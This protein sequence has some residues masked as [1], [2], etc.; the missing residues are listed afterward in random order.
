MEMR[1][2]AII[3][4]A[5]LGLSVVCIVTL[6]SRG[7][8]Y[9][10]E[11]EGEPPG[12]AVVELFT[13][14]GCSSCP[15]AAELA[16]EL[17]QS[18]LESE[19]SVYFL[20]FHVDYWNYLG[21][22]DDFSSKEFT[23]RQQ[24]YVTR[25]GLQSAYTPQMVVNGEREF[26]GSNRSRAK[27]AIDSGLEDGAKIK[28]DLKGCLIQ[29][30]SN[31]KVVYALNRNPVGA[32]LFLALVE[33][34]IHRTILRGENSG[35]TLRHHN[36]VRTLVRITDLRQTEAEVAVPPGTNYEKCAII[37]FVQEENGMKIIGAASLDISGK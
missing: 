6:F 21:W 15:A 27:E 2:T 35:R 33:R 11:S 29:T 3:I 23:Q 5:L 16:A 19:R 34:G 7:K 20:S 4:P 32:V 1:K 37:A 9:D 10:P 31:I 24:Q 8:V 22:N 17:D 18:Y 30:D 14:E 13:S 26:V 36:V 25:F 12:F 28:I